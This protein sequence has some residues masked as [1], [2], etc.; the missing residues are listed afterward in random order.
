MP[1]ALA[2][3]LLLGTPRTPNGQSVAI[4]EVTVVPM[5]REG[6]VPRQTVVVR[7]DRIVAV[8]PSADTP[9]PPD[10]TV[11]DGRGRYLLPGL[12]DGHV[13]LAG[14]VFGP[15]RPEFGD[16]PLYLAYGV[17]TV[18]NLG[19]TP[20]HLEWRRR[21]TAGELPGPTIYTSPPFFNEPRVSAG[22]PAP[23]TRE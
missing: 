18:F 5:D 16:A 7:G 12:T 17:T 9:I 23:L 1:L 14:T 2:A 6:L 19:G 11:I 4:A 10:A 3:F 20:E 13:H 15:G 8:G 21:V 22:F